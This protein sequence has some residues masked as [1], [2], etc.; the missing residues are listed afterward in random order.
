MIPDISYTDGKLNAIRN[1]DGI[2]INSSV[3]TEAGRFFKKHGYYV[4]DPWGTSAWYDYWQEER[5][6]CIEG[7]TVSGVKITGEHYFYLNYTPIQKVDII[8]GNRASKIEGFPDFWDGDFNYFWVREIAKNGIY[9][10]LLSPEKFKEFTANPSKFPDLGKQLFESLKL[11]VKIP[12]VTTIELDG[13]KY[14]K[15]NL[16]GGFNLIV[17]KSRRKGY[18]L[19]NSSIAANNFLTIPNSYTALAAYE[20]RFLYPGAIF[21]YTLDLLN[22]INTSTGW[23]MPSDVL[24]RA[25]HIRSSYYEYVNGLKLEKGFKSEIQAVSFKDNP[26]ALR[27][28]NA[29]DIYFE[30]AG[31]FGVP[32][33]LKLSY[34]ASEPC[35]MAGK[36]KTGMIT[37][38]GTSGDTEHGTADYADMHSRPEAFNLLPFLNIWDKDSL[39]QKTGFF[40]P[41]DWNMEGLYDQQGNSNR[42]AA[43]DLELLTRKRLIKNGALYA[44][45]QQRMQENPLSPSEAFGAIS[46]N[47]FP[48]VEL[49]HQLQKVKANNWQFVKGMPV[50]LVYEG[51]EVI[52]K[53]ILNNSR[54]P[55]TSYYNIPLNK[56]GCVVIYEQAVPDPPKNLYKIGYDPVMQ[57]Q[58]TSLAGIAVYKGVHTSTQYHSI[59]VAE[60]IGRMES[61]E[62]MDRL[63][64]MLAVYYNTQIMHENEVTGV[65]TY[66]QRNKKLHLL[67]GQPNAVIS[68][69]V[70]LSKV[71]RVY[72]C[73]MAE[74]LKDAGERYVKDWLLTTLD[75][76]E[77]GNKVRVLDRIYSIRLLEELIA[78]NRKGNFD[79]ISALFMCMFQVQ[80]EVL[81]KKYD[82]M[83]VHPKGKKLIDMMGR[84]Y[85]KHNS[86]SLMA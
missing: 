15:D 63:A 54:E 12:P 19:K 42:K 23:V 70:K 49:K 28:K 56:A 62:D 10:S 7:Y 31:A 14:V 37:L 69:N 27:G 43:Q 79:L 71:A 75:Y 80:E 72:G 46:I 77:N 11:E 51:E 39:N 50:D 44:D 3:F 20:K 68:K 83:E 81:G 76:D 1:P 41:I 47:N 59:L 16:E 35:V 60:Y 53:P 38:F 67:A 78:Y 9:Q 36:I 13:Q 48:V 84:M 64:E 29:K 55:I 17:G 24:K 85:Q 58:G 5:K 61:A 74:P 86:H 52:I 33:L 8:T 73:H 40:H 25:D 2:W 18:S 30:E 26:D 22:F 82:S 6:R 65:K 45:I 66:F 34:S 32:G 4:S 57:D 21:S